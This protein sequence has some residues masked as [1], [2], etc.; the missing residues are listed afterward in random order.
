[1][2]TAVVAANGLGTERFVHTPAVQV[3]DN[4]EVYV[5]LA[6]IPAGSVG[7]PAGTIYVRPSDGRL[8][9]TV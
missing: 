1:M 2:T 3:G 6:T 8:F 5:D 4:N 7:L 9:R